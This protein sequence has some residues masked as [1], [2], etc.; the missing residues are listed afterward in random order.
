MNVHI[1]TTNQGLQEPRVKQTLERL[2][3]EARG[4]A[5]V[6]LRGLP[7]ALAAKM[8]GKSMFDGF[9]PHM[10]NA[11]IQISHGAGE[12]IYNTARAIGAKRIVEFGTSFGVSTIYLACAVRDNGGG[13]VIGSELEPEKVKVARQNI[14][15]AGLESFV[16]V[17]EGDAL[18]TLAD[19][20]GPIDLVLLDG[21]KDL[22]IPIVKMLTPK[23]RRGSA[24]FADNINTFKKTLRPYVTR[25][26]DPQNGYVTTTL[27]IGSG[28]EYS[29]Y[30][31]AEN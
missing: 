16:E 24:V 28:L 3:R 17:R 14:A 27:S 4:D 2:H 20:E 13:K 6:F 31:G 12:A 10:K 1:R 30:V 11:F 23:L 5:L 29:V 21:W 8:R 9:E 15:S 26:R 19:V 18:Q 25:M 22:Y 7:D